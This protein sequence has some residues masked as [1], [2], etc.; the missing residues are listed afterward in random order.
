M[1]YSRHFCEVSGMKHFL[2]ICSTNS[3][4]R[5]A[6]LRRDNKLNL[7][8]LYVYTA[9]VKDY[10]DN[11]RSSY[12]LVFTMKPL[13]TF[14]IIDKDSGARVAGKLFGKFKAVIDLFLSILFAVSFGDKNRNFCTCN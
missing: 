3:G 4:Y 14:V 8:S 10:A 9:E 11:R 2:T 7:L 13:S 1:S 12:L 5:C 6:E